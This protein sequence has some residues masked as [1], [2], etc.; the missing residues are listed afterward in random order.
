M[1][2]KTVH[3]IHG[4]L[5]AADYDSLSFT[6]KVITDNGDAEVNALFDDG[7]ELLDI[8]MFA[9]NGVLGDTLV[10]VREQEDSEGTRRLSLPTHL[11]DDVS[12]FLLGTLDD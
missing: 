7:W 5:S 4:K 11:D 8:Q 9:E 12:N 6:S 2:L 1:E 10:F 3:R